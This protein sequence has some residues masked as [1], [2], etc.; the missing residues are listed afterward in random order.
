MDK[1]TGLRS[2]SAFP[3]TRT[4]ASTQRGVMCRAG[5]W[6]AAIWENT[7]QSKQKPHK[8]NA[9]ST[10]QTPERQSSLLR[11]EGRENRRGVIR[12]SH[13]RYDE[14]EG[15]N[16]QVR[17]RMEG[18]SR[19]WEEREAAG[20]QRVKTHRKVEWWQE[21]EWQVEQMWTCT[22]W[23]AIGQDNKKGDLGRTD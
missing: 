10:V 16:G 23:R 1:F 13:A 14:R 4:Y 7:S 17:R 19:G 8:A 12:W 18:Q 21:R 11:G 9:C 3:N 15:N 6:K 2:V 5:L 20:G 22:Q